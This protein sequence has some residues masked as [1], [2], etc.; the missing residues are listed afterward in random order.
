MHSYASQNLVKLC[1]NLRTIPEVFCRRFDG[2]VGDGALK[3][4]EDEQP[5]ARPLC[6]ELLEYSRKAANAVAAYHAGNRLANLS[7]HV[8][9]RVP[10]NRPYSALRRSAYSPGLLGGVDPPL[11]PAPPLLPGASGAPP[12]CPPA[13]PEELL[14]VSTAEPATALSPSY[15]TPFT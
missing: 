3:T 8:K 9:Y 13:S 10:A 12:G 15:S 11:P 14:D 7:S 4:K 5:F 1:A 2:L 6:A